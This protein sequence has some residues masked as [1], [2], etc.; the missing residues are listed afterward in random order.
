MNWCVQYFVDYNRYMSL[1]GVFVVF[2]LLYAL[3]LNRRAISWSLVLKAVGVHFFLTAL[4]LLTSVGQSF[5]TALATGVQAL[6][7]ASDAGISFLFGNL[8]QPAAGSWGFIFAI[9]VLPVMVFFGAFMALLSYCGVIR[10]I[11]LL[12]RKVLQPVLRTDGAETSCAIAN[13]FLGQTEAP[14]LIRHYLAKLTQSE[15]F[16]VMVSGM[17]TISGAVLGVYG[18]MGVPLKHLLS[19]SI[20]AIPATIF[21][22]K[23][24]VPS[25]PKVCSE[26][27]VDRGSMATSLFEAVSIGTSDGLMLALNVGA[28]LIAFIALIG[29]FNG[30]LACGGVY[31]N[32]LFTKLGL[33]WSLPTLS[34]EMIFG[35]LGRPFG[36][37]LGLTGFD[38]VRLGELLGLKVAV[39]EMV[40][41]SAMVTGGL[42]ERATILATYVLC[43]FSNF[44]SIGIQ[45]GGIGILAPEQ[46]ARIAQ[47]GLRAVCVAALANLYS[48]LIVNLFI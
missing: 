46:R 36:W 25:E 29:L 9:R 10:V 33:A 47:L 18:V 12:V 2:G 5:V 15:L 38:A 43:G 11:V 4:M 48:A 35:I 40:A 20:I 27:E 19:A 30:V 14:L 24:V 8:A 34:L 32:V 21:C 1:F 3:S 42:S 6:Y 41:Y 7:K 23:I 17:G 37:L 39:N 13:S 28:M 31:I 26:I 45:V 16:V 22:A 44:S